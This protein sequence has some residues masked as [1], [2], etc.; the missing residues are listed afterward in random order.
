MSRGQGRTS[1]RRSRMAPEQLKATLLNQAARLVV[2]P[3]GMPARDALRKAATELAL[4]PR[5]LRVDDAEL[6]AA[7]SGYRALFHR[8]AEPRLREQRRTALEAM[9]FFAAFQPRL[10]GAALEGTSS[11]AEAVQIQ[12][13]CDDEDAVIRLL[14]EHGMA[15]EYAAGVRYEGPGEALKVPAL[16]MLAGEVAV[17][18]LIMPEQLL[19]QALRRA[20]H[21]RIE[22]RADSAEL[23]R[24]LESS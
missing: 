21:E 19:R 15:F 6:A 7:V 1:M 12:L 3:P 5:D 14:D 9:R 24:M 23:A 13:F 22:R 17:S 20:G 11:A 8:D 18:L 2:Q 4:D 10:V 16:R